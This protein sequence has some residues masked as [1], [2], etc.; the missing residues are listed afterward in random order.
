MLNNP[1]KAKKVNLFSCP[2]TLNLKAIKESI[3]L[4]VKI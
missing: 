2:T 3:E 1:T 4:R